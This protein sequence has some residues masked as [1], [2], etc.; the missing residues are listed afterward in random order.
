MTDDMIT[1]ES[2]KDTFFYIM[3]SVISIGCAVT[4]GG[5]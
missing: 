5:I 4:E 3:N 2:G 1:I